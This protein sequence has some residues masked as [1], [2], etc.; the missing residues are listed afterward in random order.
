MQNIFKFYAVMAKLQY[1]PNLRQSHDDFIRGVDINP[2]MP[3]DN[4]FDNLQII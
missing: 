4:P 3:I 2:N 1:V